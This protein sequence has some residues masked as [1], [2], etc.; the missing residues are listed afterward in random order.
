MKKNKNG[1]KQLKFSETKSFTVKMLMKW[2][3]DRNLW[4]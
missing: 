2:K 3:C 4:Y 1:E